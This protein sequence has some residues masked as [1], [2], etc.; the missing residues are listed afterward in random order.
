[1]ILARVLTE[2]TS[3]LSEDGH[4]FLEDLSGQEWL[5]SIALRRA[6]TRAMA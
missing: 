1:M 5:A 6:N 3:R 2:Q 4:D